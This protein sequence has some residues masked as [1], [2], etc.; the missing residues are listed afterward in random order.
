MNGFDEEGRGRMF[1][2]NHLL[3]PSAFRWNNTDLTYSSHIFHNNFHVQSFCK[4][5]LEY[6]NRIRK[7]I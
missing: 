5:N 3:T 4:H 6:K 7:V 1:A 2:Y